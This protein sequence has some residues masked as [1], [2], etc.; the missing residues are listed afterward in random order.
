MRTQ[1]WRKYIK[2]FL[3]L[4]YLC[5]FNSKFFNLANLVLNFL[6]IYQL[7]SFDQFDLKLLIWTPVVL[8][9]MKSTDVDNFFKFFHFLL[10][11]SFFVPFFLFLWARDPV[12]HKDF[13]QAR[14]T[15]PSPNM[16]EAL[17]GSEGF[18]RVRAKRKGPRR[19]CHGNL[20]DCG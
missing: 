16:G 20:T 12:G 9:D 10:F 2:K 7:N 1:P 14:A 3:N 8:H 19:P 17:T 13:V 4:L 5:K 15:A 11:L 6:T 18:P